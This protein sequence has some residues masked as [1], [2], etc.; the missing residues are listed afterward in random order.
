V[1]VAQIDPLS[2]AATRVGDRLSARG[3]AVLSLWASFDDPVTVLLTIYAAGWVGTR[4]GRAVPAADGSA[5]HQ[6][7]GFA[8]G[9]WRNV[10]FAFTAY[11]LW[12]LLWSLRRW[13]S[14]RGSRSGWMRVLARVPD[15]GAV[16]L[17]AG[18]VA[19]AV[20]NFLMLGLALA[21]LVVRPRLGR[22][23]D[24]GTRAAFYIAAF[25]VGLLLV[26]G[27]D[28]GPAVLLGIT[29]VVAQAVVSVPIARRLPAK[30][31]AYLA[32]GQQNGVTA[33]ILA[34]LLEPDFPGTVGLV[35]PA[36]LII[37]AVYTVWNAAI[38]RY[39]GTDR[40]LAE[41]EAERVGV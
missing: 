24:I 3:R 9:M 25:L 11:A 12:W 40:S 18:L 6:L 1:I 37:N 39:Y 30:D 17:L 15:A 16:L 38:D 33:V 29:A 32:A 34:V 41:V 10:F 36:I 20:W 26:H 8:E 13:V 27:V 35:A 2:V 14:E 7:L 4:L 23:L 28:L 5:A 22:A 19:F 21:G 31:R